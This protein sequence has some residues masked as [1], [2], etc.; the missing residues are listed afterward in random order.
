MRFFNLLIGCHHKKL[1]FPNT[2]CEIGSLTGRVSPTSTYVVCPDC[3]RG[4]PYDWNAMK[5]IRHS[6][7]PSNPPTIE[8]VPGVAKLAVPL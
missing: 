1:S 3:G 5:V 2:L 7:A 4:L 6:S 8:P